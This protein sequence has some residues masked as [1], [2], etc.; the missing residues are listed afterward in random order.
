[1]KAPEVVKKVP[2][3]GMEDRILEGWKAYQPKHCAYNHILN[4]INQSIWQKILKKKIGP[5]KTNLNCLIITEYC[6]KKKKVNDI[7]LSVLF[8]DWDLIDKWCNGQ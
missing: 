5:A 7:T 1:M 3:F 8:H 4:N 2:K 6:E